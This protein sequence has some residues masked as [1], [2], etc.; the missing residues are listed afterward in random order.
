VGPAVD[1]LTRV[2]DAPASWLPTYGHSPGAAL[3]IEEHDGA[4]S[5]VAVERG[6]EVERRTTN[7]L[8]ELLYWVFEGVTSRMANGWELEHRVEGADSRKL[9][10]IKQFELL[11]RLNSSWVDRRRSVLRDVLA[12]IGLDRSLEVG[13]Q[14]RVRRMFN[15]AV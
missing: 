4:L 13:P 11:G 14:N 6:E 9:R 2:I 3:Y 10:F 15:Q 12:Q 7:D 8:D 5:Y 1:R